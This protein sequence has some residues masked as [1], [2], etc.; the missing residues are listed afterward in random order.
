MKKRFFVSSQ[1]EALVMKHSCQVLQP[2][3]PGL[4]PLTTRETIDL[5]FTFCFLWFIANWSI[6]AALGYTSV[7]SAT[8]L[9][10]MSGMLSLPTLYCMVEFS[11]EGFFTLGIGRLFMVE[12]LTPAKIAAV[13]I[14][15]VIHR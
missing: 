5:A 7:A 11:C 3:T 12:R 8:I 9:S 14:R 6:N 1:H 10:S 2:T 4:R 13:L 15:Y